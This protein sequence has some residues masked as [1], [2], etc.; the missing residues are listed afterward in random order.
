MTSAWAEGWRAGRPSRLP[1]LVYQS[2]SLSIS[3]DL[4]PSLFEQSDTEQLMY[5]RQLPRSSNA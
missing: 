1:P 2:E 5:S 3:S 4:F